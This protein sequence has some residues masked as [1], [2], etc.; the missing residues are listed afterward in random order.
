MDISVR[1]VEEQAFRE[2]RVKAVSKGLTTGIALSQ[3]MREWA[4]KPEKKPKKSFFDLKP[5]AWK[6]KNA[7][8]KVDESLY[9]GKK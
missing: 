9:G 1:E 5:W 6:E 8:M 7:S 2:F 4:G 3:A